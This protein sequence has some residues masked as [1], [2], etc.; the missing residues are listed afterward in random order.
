M[1]DRE[2]QLPAALDLRGVFSHQQRHD[3][4]SQD[5]LRG[6]QD[7]CLSLAIHRLAH[8]AVRTWARTRGIYSVRFGY[9]GGIQISVLLAR[10][11]KS[12]ARD[13]LRFAGFRTIEAAEKAGY[14]HDGGC[15]EY[16]PQGAM[17]YHLKNDA[18]LDATLD[19]EHPEVLV[20][21]KK[22]DGAFKLNGVEFLVPISAWTAAEPPR[23][24]GQALKKVDRLGI[25]Y[26]HVWVW[27][28]SP[29]GLFADWNPNVKCAN[30]ASDPQAMSHP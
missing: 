23:I 2:R 28:P 16:Q 14:R 15:V 5:L 18:L 8:R 20:Y 27:E 26:L 21:E 10:V 9:L 25:W 1:G 11:C 22:P 24:L 12:L 13:V 17:G 30:A 4:L 19:L 6:K 29:S 7:R 3:L